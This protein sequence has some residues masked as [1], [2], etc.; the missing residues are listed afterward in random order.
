M[1]FKMDLYANVRPVR[2]AGRD[3]LCPLKDIEPKDIDFVVVREN[4]E[5]AYVDAGGVFKQGTPDE[6]AVQ[7]DINTR[8]G[9]ERVIRYAFEY[10]ER[11]RSRT[12]AR[13][14]AC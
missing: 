11:H 13:A 5:G 2:L 6:I 1:R 10:C 8:K 7:E 14:S 12:A 9:V 4:T 3:R